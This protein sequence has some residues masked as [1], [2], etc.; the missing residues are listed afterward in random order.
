MVFSAFTGLMV[1]AASSTLTREVSVGDDLGMR[2][3]KG[4]GGVYDIRRAA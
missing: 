3:V 1:R 4:S 2:R